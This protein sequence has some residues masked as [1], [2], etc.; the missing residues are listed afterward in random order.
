MD[1]TPQPARVSAQLVFLRRLVTVLT[2]TMI[3]GMVLITTLFVIRF[4]GDR[5]PAGTQMALPV[6]IT[7]PHGTIATAFTQGPNWYAVV[8][9]NDEI[10]IFDLATGALRQTLVILPPM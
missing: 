2:I 3:A 5:V 8:T 10:L 7:L 6:A 1:P 9:A 4:S